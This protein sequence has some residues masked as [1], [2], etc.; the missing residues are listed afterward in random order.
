MKERK[1]EKERSVERGRRSGSVED[2]LFLKP[3]FGT[4]WIGD[5]WR[6]MKANS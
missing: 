6:S 2:S 5:P 1:K 3:R 4:L